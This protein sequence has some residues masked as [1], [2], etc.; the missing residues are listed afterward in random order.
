MQNVL[1]PRLALK[2]RSIGRSVWFWEVLDAA[3][4]HVATGQ[5]YLDRDTCLAAGQHA[6]ESLTGQTPLLPELAPARPIVEQGRL[7][8]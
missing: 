8:L 5:T 2:L 1:A 7:P 6:L 3:G 4:C